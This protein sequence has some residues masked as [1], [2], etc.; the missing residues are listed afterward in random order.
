MSMTME[1]QTA[2]WWSKRKFGCI[3]L[4]LSLAETLIIYGAAVLV[5]TSRQPHASPSILRM[6]STTWLV[7]GLGSL[8]FAVAGLVV[9]SHRTTALIALI[10]TIVTFLV[11][12]LQVLV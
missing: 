10:V 7:G 6:A 12:G 2:T 8:G 9:D 1:A 5:Q 11:C 4:A 3:S